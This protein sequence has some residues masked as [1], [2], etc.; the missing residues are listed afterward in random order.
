MCSFWAT[1]QIPLPI[2]CRSTKI[3]LS[4]GPPELIQG[5]DIE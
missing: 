3:P 1:D 2:R 4:V 5:V